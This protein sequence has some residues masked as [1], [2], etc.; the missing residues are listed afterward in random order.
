M[1]DNEAAIRRDVAAAGFDDVVF[2]THREV[3]HEVDPGAKHAGPL[4]RLVNQIVNHLSEQ[5]AY[6]EQYEAATRAGRKV[7][8]VRVDGRPEA[9]KVKEVL[10]K[11]DVVD[12]R[13]FGKLAVEDL[14]PGTN[15]SAASDR[16]P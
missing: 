5:I 7:V 14:T 6:L 15:P 12:L 8:A 9:H 13:F 3:D 4:A 2:L 11:H 1:S 16:V 10:E